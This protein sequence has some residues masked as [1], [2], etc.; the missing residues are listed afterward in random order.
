MVETELAVL[1]LWRRGLKEREIASTLGVHR[2]TVN[3]YTRERRQALKETLRVRALHLYSLD[4]LSTHQIASYMGIKQRRV[5]MWV[6]EAG[7]SR[8]RRL[9]LRF[10]RR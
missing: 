7:L 4:G 10:R 8:P 3:G 5:A 2:T 1:Q 9:A 6:R